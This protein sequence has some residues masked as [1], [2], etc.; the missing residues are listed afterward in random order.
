MTHDPTRP[1]TP[2]AEQSLTFPSELSFWNKV[3]RVLWGAVWLFLFRPSPR[4]LFCWRRFLLRLF[5]AKV[6]RGVRVYPS[7]RIW[8]PWRLELQEYSS[9]GDGTELYNVAPIVL[10]PYCSV[11][12]HC[13][14]CTGSHDH[15]YLGRPLTSKPIRIGRH[16]WVT[17]CVFIAPGVTVGEGAVCG[18]RA[19]VVKDVEPWTVVAGNPAKV[20]GKREILEEG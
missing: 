16:A 8:A 9:A 3:G 12:Q 10:E 14:L 20:I 19:V 7:T 11:S 13:F 18:A 17:A 5:G 2:E 15:R 6:S 4:P 1:Y